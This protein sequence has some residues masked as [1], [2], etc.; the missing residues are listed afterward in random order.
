MNGFNVNIRI[1]MSSKEQFEYRGEGLLVRAPAKLNLSLLVGCK[2]ADGFHE[3][4]TVMTKIDL[5]DELL[6]EIHESEITTVVPIIKELME[7][8]APTAHLPYTVGV[9]YSRESWFDKKTIEDLSKLSE[10]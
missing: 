9:D 3:I 1:Y 8:V 4:S 6:F 10:I 2:R 7:T 5:Y